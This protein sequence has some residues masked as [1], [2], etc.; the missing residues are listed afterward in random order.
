[1]VEGGDLGDEEGCRGE[2]EVD[3]D[4]VKTDI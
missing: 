1:M 3:I 2:P 4:S